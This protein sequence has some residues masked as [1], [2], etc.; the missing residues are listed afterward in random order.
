MP[1]KF[2]VCLIPLL[3]IS[4][5]SAA[6]QEP[7]PSFYAFH[8]MSTMSLGTG[9][10]PS[11]V[12]RSKIRCIE[13]EESP[14]EK[15]ALATQFTTKLVTNSEQLQT[16]LGLDTKIDASY[17]VYKGGASFSFKYSMSSSEDSAT[18]VVTA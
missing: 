16:S 4:L 2:L 13:G 9:F 14:L 3:L 8:P 7:D 12:G 1:Q 17:L 18:L 10:S 5:P 15:G 6:E 11:D